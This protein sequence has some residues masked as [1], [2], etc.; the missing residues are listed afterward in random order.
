MLISSRLVSLALFIVGAT[1]HLLETGLRPPR[2]H[3]APQRE[4]VN[5]FQRQSVCKA[6]VRGGEDGAASSNRTGVPSDSV[7]A[8]LING[9]G[10]QREASQCLTCSPMF[11]GS[12]SCC[13]FAVF[14]LLFACHYFGTLTL[15]R[16]RQSCDAASPLPPP[17]FLL[18]L[19]VTQSFSS[20][21]ILHIQ[22]VSLTVLQAVTQSTGDSSLL[23]P[24]GGGG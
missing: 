13:L 21:P 1:R 6:P 12:E 9:T 8:A 15:G 16:A 11:T 20:S 10:R 17:P 2:P 14:S 3:S 22:A 19:R 23:F 5:V 7:S 24:R 18:L 4:L